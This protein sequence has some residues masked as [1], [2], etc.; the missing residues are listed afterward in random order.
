MVDYII[1][2]DFGHGE[3]SVA[4][5]CVR[6]I[7]ESSVSIPVEDIKISGND[8]VIPS[9][10][11]Y[12][13][14]HEV[15]I[16]I[17][18][19]EFQEMRI[20]AYFKAPMV[21]SEE[22][23][24]ITQENKIYFRDFAQAVIKS[25]LANPK[26]SDLIGKTIDWYIACPSGWNPEQM[27]SYM[28]FFNDDC[29]LNISSVI[30]E[31]RSAYIRARRSISSQ[32]QAG[33]SIGDER[34]AVFD[35][36][37]STLDIT[38]HD[39]EHARTHGYPCG[40]SK[41]EEVI[42]DY[43]YNK[44]EK[45]KCAIDSFIQH[46]VN[47]TLQK[48]CVYIPQILYLIRKEKESF[49]NKIAKNPNIDCTF[50]CSIDIN[51]LSQGR[52][53]YDENLKL[54]RNQLEKI[55]SESGY[56]TE[57]IQSLK[58]F[59]LKYGGIDAAVLTGGASNMYFFQNYVKDVFELE[60]K[61]CIVDPKPSYSISQGIAMIGYI[62][63][64]IRE[65]GGGRDPLDWKPIKDLLNSINTIMMDT[66]NDVTRNIYKSELKDSI[67]KW[68]SCKIKYEGNVSCMSLADAFDKILEGWHKN[69]ATIS[70]RIN[71]G[72]GNILSNQ[73][74]SILREKL[75][76]YY[77]RDV[78]IEKPSFHFDFPISLTPESIKHLS[79]LFWVCLI[80]T[81]NSNHFFGWS[82][83]SANKDRSDDPED[84]KLIAGAIKNMVD[85]YFKNV[86]YADS[87]EDEVLECKNMTIDLIKRIH[88]NMIQE[89]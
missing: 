61:K 28:A 50:K 58:A 60:S 51:E 4:K 14:E 11:A 59:R 31:S 52:V 9:L 43:F 48:G 19:E 47:T 30:K 55:L 2:I 72:V 80:D 83:K 10:V 77:G 46:G 39:T 85:E 64:R 23:D 74:S 26:N 17:E 27:S 66:I 73:I 42:Y 67:N 49:Y 41:V 1:G 16:D 56:Y 89:F 88:R 87:I 68:E 70:N 84:R 18:P 13:E 29:Q 36:G 20:G 75:R 76:L 81:I 65:M 79:E 6:N 5:V 15:C 45:F 7:S 62:E 22:Y 3:T 54:S 63:S 33:I 53:N 12:N 44:D 38:L 40:A 34:I 24:E 71:E 78:E 35:M 37:S 21:G 82:E 86:K 25:V 57:I 32:N 69:Y 8:D